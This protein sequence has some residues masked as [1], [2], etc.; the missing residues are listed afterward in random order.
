MTTESRWLEGATMLVESIRL[1]RG[2]NPMTTRLVWKKTTAAD[3][4]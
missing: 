3:S 1:G 2:G 4:M